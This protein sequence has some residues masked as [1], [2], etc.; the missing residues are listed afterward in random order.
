MWRHSVSERFRLVP[1]L[2]SA[3]NWGIVQ[4]TETAL[5]RWFAVT[6]DRKTRLDAG[7]FCRVDPSRR[8]SAAPNIIEAVSEREFQRIRLVALPSHEP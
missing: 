4:R 7:E 8:H 3:G 5:I 6:S 2:T 1:R